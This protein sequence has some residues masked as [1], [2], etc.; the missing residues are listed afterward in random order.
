[1]RAAKAAKANP[2]VQSTAASG[3]A[4]EKPRSMTEFA[5]DSDRRI[6]NY[7]N[8]ATAS[9]EQDTDASNDAQA[10]YEAAQKLW[11]DGGDV[12]ADG[13]KVY[14]GQKAYRPYTEKPE[15]FDS[16]VNSG[17]GPARAPVHYR[18]TSRFDYQPDVCKDY[19]D[20]GFCGYGDACKFLH[21]RSDY[22]SGWQLER[23]WEEAERAKR[24][25]AALEELEGPSG[26]NAG[27]GAGSALF[28]PKK[29]GVDDDRLP[30]ACLICRE[31]WH[32]KSR[33][34]VTRCE[35]YFCEACALQHSV[36]TRRCFV[37]AENTAGI[38]NSAKAIQAKIDARVEAEAAEGELDAKYDD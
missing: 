27:S 17:H 32:A 7:D 21:D 33:P 9:N 3:A 15:G 23:D 18:A 20:T 6:S 24:H 31:P 28:L 25:E 34:V 29:S 8:K 13:S 4:P 11:E 1:V 2:L 35:H 19:K 10:Q 16:R 5:H 26:G 22:K 14:R 12:A 36:K 30:F 37:C 38:F